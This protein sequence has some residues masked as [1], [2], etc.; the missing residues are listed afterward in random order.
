MHKF[1]RRFVRRRREKEYVRLSHRLA[2][3]EKAEQLEPDP[4]SRFY[5]G[6][7]RAQVATQRAKLGT[8]LQ[9][10]PDV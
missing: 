9:E 7:V 3:L 2:F 10:A 8:K 5:I 1:I 4:D 6:R